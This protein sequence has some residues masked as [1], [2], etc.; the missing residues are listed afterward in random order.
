MCAQHRQPQHGC[1]YFK[2]AMSSSCGDPDLSLLAAKAVKVLQ[3]LATRSYVA[4]R[5]WPC[6]ARDRCAK[7][8]ATLM[9]LVRC[10]TTLIPCPVSSVCQTMAMHASRLRKG[11]TQPRSELRLPASSLRAHHVLY[12]AANTLYTNCD[13]VISVLCD[14]S[15]V[16]AP[17][18]RCMLDSGSRQLTAPCLPQIQ[19]IDRARALTCKSQA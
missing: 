10:T 17:K 8:C 12:C 1:G 4:G 13:F 6:G 2:G 19:Q 15:A 5:V 16:R 7:H 3:G 11:L 14:R 9:A 18:A